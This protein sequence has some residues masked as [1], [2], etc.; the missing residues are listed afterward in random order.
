[1]ADE[2][3]EYAG[4]LLL[5][6][7][8]DEYQRFAAQLAAHFGEQQGFFAAYIVARTCALGPARDV[9]PRQVIDWATEAVNKDDRQWYYHAHALAQFRAGSPYLAIDELRKSDAV[10]WGISGVQNRF[11][12]AMTHHSLGNRTRARQLFYWGKSEIDKSRHSRLVKLDVC[13]PDWIELEVL[14]REAGALIDADAAHPQRTAKET[15]ADELNS[16]RV[17]FNTYEKLTADFPDVSNYRSSLASAANELSWKLATSTFDQMRD[18]KQAVEIATKA[19]ELTDYK[20]P[21]IVDT[22]AAAYAERGDFD[23]AVKWSEKSLNLLGES[24][25]SNSRKVFERALA[26][27]KAKKATRQPIIEIGGQP[28]VGVTSEEADPTDLQTAN[29]EAESTAQDGP[30]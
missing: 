25:D 7:D 9:S 29:P 21:N 16:A 6:G 14:Y 20:D 18:G 19:C 3:F 11:L 30:K 8:K 5:S 15:S 1:M 13:V 17:E 2:T 24:E 22:L 4:L 12:L 26:N 27:Y 28:A 10:W 23:S